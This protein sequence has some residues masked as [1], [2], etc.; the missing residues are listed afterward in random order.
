MFA[1]FAWYEKVEAFMGG[2]RIIIRGLA[3]ANLESCI[4]KHGIRSSPV[5]NLLSNFD[6]KETRSSSDTGGIEKRQW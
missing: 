6:I 5:V 1:H 2:L 4:I 3:N